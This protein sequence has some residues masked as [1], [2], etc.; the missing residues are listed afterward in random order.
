MCRTACTESQYLYKGAHTKCDAVVWSPTFRVN[1]GFHSVML[2]VINL[3]IRVFCTVYL[4]FYFVPL[5]YFFILYRLFIFYF[6]PFIYFL[7]CTVYLFFYFVP[8]IY[9]LFCTV[10][11]FFYFVPF[12]YFFILYRLF[13]FFIFGYPSNSRSF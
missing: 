7:F 4:F 1:R 2:L 3:A 12:I 13:I 11:L 10:Y 6:V 5:I 9:F 8:F